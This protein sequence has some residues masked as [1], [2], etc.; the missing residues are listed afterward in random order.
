MSDEFL[1]VMI[2]VQPVASRESFALGNENGRANGNANHF[3]ELDMVICSRSSQDNRS[4]KA[5]TVRFKFVI[6]K[7]FPKTV[8]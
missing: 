8:F 2:F 4:R 5:S 6:D 1:S 3:N 7:L